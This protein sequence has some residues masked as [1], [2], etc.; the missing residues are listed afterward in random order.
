MS[1]SIELPLREAVHKNLSLLEYK[2]PMPLE[3]QWWALGWERD[4]QK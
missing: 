2:V 4:L 3:R 1:M